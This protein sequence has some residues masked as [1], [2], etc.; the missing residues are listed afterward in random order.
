MCVAL[1]QVSPHQQELG[2]KGKQC[3]TCPLPACSLA[4]SLANNNSRTESTTTKDEAQAQKGGG[5]MKRKEKGKREKES[6]TRARIPGLLHTPQQS[7]SMSEQRGESGG[8]GQSSRSRLE[9]KRERGGEDKAR[10]R[11]RRYTKKKR[12][13]RRRRRR[14]KPLA[15]MMVTMPNGNN[16]NDNYK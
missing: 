12:R 5:R 6:Y 10:R 9:E 8:R 4:R 1:Q 13:R 16:C 2:K 3:H 14:R 7:D 11:Q 15:M